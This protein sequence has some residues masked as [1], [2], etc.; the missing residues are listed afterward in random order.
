MLTS[1]WGPT[2]C[3]WGTTQQCL[4]SKL[5]LMT[6]PILSH[7]HDLKIN[8]C[9]RFIWVI[10]KS[11]EKDGIHPLAGGGDGLWTPTHLNKDAGPCS[12]VVTVS[13][14]PPARGPLT[15]C[16]QRSLIHHHRA[17]HM[18]V[19][20]ASEPW[21][22]LDNKTIYLSGSSSVSAQAAFKPKATWW[23]PPL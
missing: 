13:S 10:P 8:I 23:P 19:G 7:G 15:P 21:S 16:P 1:C 9:V 18:W 11:G 3:N 4:S 14:W 6:W 20:S 12:G 5:W 2:H 17:G 22:N